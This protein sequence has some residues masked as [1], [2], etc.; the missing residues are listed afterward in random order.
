MANFIS[1]ALFA[2]TVIVSSVINFAETGSTCSAE[3]Q[4]EY[5]LTQEEQIDLYEQVMDGCIDY[6]QAQD[7]MDTDECCD[8]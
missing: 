8:F 4:S 5:Q 6:E 7:Q 3:Y 2:L 1:C